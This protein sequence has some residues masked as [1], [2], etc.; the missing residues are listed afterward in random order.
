MWSLSSTL[1]PVLKALPFLLAPGSPASVWCVVL[2]CDVTAQDPPGL[3]GLRGWLSELGS[4]L[5]P[6]SEPGPAQ[7]GGAQPAWKHPTCTSAR[8]EASGGGP[9]GAPTLPGQGQ[10]PLCD[11]TSADRCFCPHARVH[12]WAWTLRASARL[13]PWLPTDCWQGDCSLQAL[14]LM[15]GCRPGTGTSVP[16]PSFH[17]TLSLHGEATAAGAPPPARAAHPGPPQSRVCSHCRAG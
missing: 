8:D 6:N 9:T 2:P 14:L 11:Q 12:V 16:A 17:L 7:V 3:P 4:Y 13:S 10:Q 1:A 15:R 5:W